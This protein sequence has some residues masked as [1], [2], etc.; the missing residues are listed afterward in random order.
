M[1]RKQVEAA[2]GNW[3]DYYKEKFLD[4]RSRQD[5]EQIMKEAEEDEAS[6]TAAASDFHLKEGE[7]A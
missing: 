7:A 2:G 4:F 3:W 1:L 6:E 5:A